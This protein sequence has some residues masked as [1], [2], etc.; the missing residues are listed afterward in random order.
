MTF[1]GKFIKSDPEICNTIYLRYALRNEYTDATRS[2][3][4]LLSNVQFVGTTGSALPSSIVAVRDSSML[5]LLLLLVVVIWETL[6]LVFIWESFMFVD[7]WESLLFVDVWDSLMSFSQ[8][9]FRQPYF[10]PRS[11]LDG[12]FWLPKLV[13]VGGEAM[14]DCDFRN[15][16]SNN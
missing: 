2:S 8:E 10:R 6:M 3:S 13:D 5:Q 16:E 14:R 4:S 12:L 9:F 7:V 15:A 1:W 11:R